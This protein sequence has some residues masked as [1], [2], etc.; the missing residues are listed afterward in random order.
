MLVGV[1]GKGKGHLLNNVVV[2]ENIKSRRP[3]AGQ[4][5]TAL[6]QPLNSEGVYAELGESRD[7]FN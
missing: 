1:L 5:S 3:S 7:L 6:T 2:S 4:H